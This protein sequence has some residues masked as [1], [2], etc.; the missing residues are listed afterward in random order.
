MLGMFADDLWSVIHG[1][2][3]TLRHFLTQLNSFQ[4]SGL[5]LNYNKTQIMRIGSLRNANAAFYTQ[6]PLHW[7]DP[8]SPDGIKV[9][10]IKLGNSDAL[11]SNFDN[12]TDKIDQIIAIWKRRA[13]SIPGKIAVINAL[14]VST[15][16]YKTLMLPLPD[17]TICEIIKKKILNFLWDDKPPRIRYT[18]AILSK[19]DG[20]LALVDLGT[21]NEAL[22]ASWIPRIIKND[23]SSFAK[24]MYYNLP[25][26]QPW[27]WEC[28]IRSTTIQK[29]F[30]NSLWTQ[31]W[32]AWSYFSYSEPYCRDAVL[33]QV[34]WYNENILRQNKPWISHTLIQ[35][36]IFRFQDIL[37]ENTDLI[38]NYWQVCHRL[39]TN[40]LDLMQYNSLVASIPQQWKD[41]L[42]IFIPLEPTI[43]DVIYKKPK[44]STYLYQRKRNT[45]KDFDGCRLA[46]QRDLNIDIDLDTWNKYIA[47]VQKIS[48]QPD[49]TYFQYRIVHQILTTN[50]LRNAWNPQVSSL[51]QFCQNY[52]ETLVHI[53]CECPKIQ[54]LWKFIEKMLQNLLRDKELLLTNKVI[55]FNCIHGPHKSFINSVILYVK[56]FIYSSKC[57][58]VL[59]TNQTLMSKLKQ[60][61]NIERLIACRLDTIRKYK[62]KWDVFLAWLYP[63]SN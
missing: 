8:A 52:P 43:L 55:I 59:P 29:L 12:L 45:F 7:V 10:G 9:L 19:I 49:L 57:L 11:K 15:L 61:Q 22:K 1:T 21:R 6:K 36:G 40:N 53:L 39:N 26:N 54:S 47:H 60:A 25:V 3:E 13:L 14:L 17:P 28:S 46:W 34:L 31:L 51:C 37:D 42:H 50:R 32:S 35:S 38:L 18:K 48:S 63:N 27:I 5:S 56:H 33:L 24:L 16:V 62:K 44:M 58:N 41:L 20:G 30:P 4:I 2:Q 23:Q